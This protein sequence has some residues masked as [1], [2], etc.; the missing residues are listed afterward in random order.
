MNMNILEHIN[1]MKWQVSTG[2]S[3][4]R[5]VANVIL[6]FKHSGFATSWFKFLFEWIISW[7]YAVL[8]DLCRFTAGFYVILVTIK[9]LGG[10]PHSIIDVNLAS[11]NGFYTVINVSIGLLVL[12]YSVVLA[13]KLLSF[14]I[15]YSGFYPIT[16]NFTGGKKSVIYFIPGTV[17]L[18]E[19]VGQ[20]HIPHFYDVDQLFVRNYISANYDELTKTNVRGADVTKYLISQEVGLLKLDRPHSYNSK[21]TGIYLKLEN[22]INFFKAQAHKLLTMLKLDELYV[23]FRQVDPNDYLFL[24]KYKYN[25]NSGVVQRKAIK[26]SVY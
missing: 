2:S 22:S 17:I 4:E 19:E 5:L 3:K 25:M 11:L 1:K 12:F 21:N 24:K 7:F 14:Q 20:K 8:I 15:N 26:K 13:S 6:L 23:A 9:L 16:R 18:W 10:N